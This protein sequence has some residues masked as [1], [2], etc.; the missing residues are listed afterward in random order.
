MD[1]DQPQLMLFSF[2]KDIQRIKNVLINKL[3]N[4]GRDTLATSSICIDFEFL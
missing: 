4:G 2:K 1:E 3:E